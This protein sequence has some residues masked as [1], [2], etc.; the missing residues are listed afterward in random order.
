VPQPPRRLPG[1]AGTG[2]AGTGPAGTGAA[3]TGPA[4]T[5]PANTAEVWR[6]SWIAV[7]HAGEI[8]DNTPVQVLLGGD[9]WVL[10]RMDGVLTA[11]DDHC[12][13]RQ[14]PL[15]AGSV[16]RAGDGSARLL[17][18]FHGWRFDAT[19]QCD[20]MPEADGGGHAHGGGHHHHRW[21]ARRAGHGRDADR[22]PRGPGAGLHAAHGVVERYGLVWLAAEEP[23]APLPEFPEWDGGT[24]GR[25]ACR[26]VTV[27]ASAGQVIDGFLDE[28]AGEVATGEWRVTGAWRPRGRDGDPAA[29]RRVTATA[30]VHATAH[31]RLELPHATI[32]I[33]V[34]CQPEDWGTTRV[35]KLVTHSALAPGTAAMERFTR[36]EDLRLA[37]RLKAVAVRASAV[38]PARPDGA[39]PGARASQLSIAW[40][41]LMARA[42][43]LP[44][45]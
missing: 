40:R 32:G 36:D 30:G 22:G 4:N 38:L 28:A 9:A 5:G 8:P 23:L 37:D 44:P 42:A 17:C 43:G 25:A 6:R 7:A 18:A 41:R 13:H 24:A 35:H 21:H 2:A 15:S 34:T 3:G 29:L 14:S 12:P 45:G 1:P 10:T 11:F 26:S 16:T 33:L 39:A 20:L 31:L 19:G 27:H